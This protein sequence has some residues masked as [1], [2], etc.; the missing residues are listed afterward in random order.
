MEEG[1]R[2]ATIDKRVAGGWSQM[3]G[4]QNLLKAYFLFKRSGLPDD[5]AKAVPKI[6]AI[7]DNYQIALHPGLR[8]KSAQEIIGRIEHEGGLIPFVRNLTGERPRDQQLRPEPTAPP[9][10]DRGSD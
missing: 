9:A 10:P 4:L 1:R 7:L 3:V 5:A 8:G 2:K 6:Q